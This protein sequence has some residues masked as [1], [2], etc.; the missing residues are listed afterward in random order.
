[1]ITKVTGFIVSSVNFK[2]S[3]LIMQI[4]TKEYGL[5]SVIG[6]GVKSL[7][8]P[9]RALTMP[10]TYGYFYLYYKE[11]KIS[12]LKD[13][14]IINPLLNIHE[15]IVLLSYLNYF[16]NLI[17]QVYKESEN[18]KLFDLL[19]ASAIKLNDGFDPEVL[20]NILEVKCLPFLGVGLTLDCCINCGSQKNIVTIDG[21]KGGL[22]CKDCYQNEPIVKLDTI[23]LLRMFMYVDINRISKLN[24]KKENK[25]E[26]NMFLT[27]Y[28]NRYTGIYLNSKDFLKKLNL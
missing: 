20:A 26:I 14:D 21:D 1:M 28:Y 4:L 19:V 13:V 22:I 18:K 25:K 7:K 6:K 10:Y 3:S 15:D 24:I 12:T 17:T 8:S 27:L 9:L 2:E 16:S 5:I 23:K 11:N